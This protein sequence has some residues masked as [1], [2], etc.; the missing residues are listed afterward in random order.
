MSKTMV[1]SAGLTVSTLA[2]RVGVGADTVC[3]YERARCRYRPAAV[4]SGRAAAWLAA[5]EI[6]T[7]LED[8]AGRRPSEPARA[9][10]A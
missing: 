8:D 2:R 3:Y 10:A 6:K 5:P 7:P 1:G 4:H 9:A